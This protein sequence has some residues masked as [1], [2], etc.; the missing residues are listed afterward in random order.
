MNSCA[1]LRSTPVSPGPLCTTARWNSPFAAGS[2]S[3]VLTFAPPPDSPKIVTLLGIAAERLDVVAHPLEREHHVE[4]TRDAGA[5]ELLAERVG[6]VQV[7][8]RVQPVVDRDDHGVAAAREL[9]PVVPA[10]PSP[11]PP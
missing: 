1:A 3:M 10:A 8:E 7:A 4:Q 11:R 2:A 6:Q 5:R 9:G